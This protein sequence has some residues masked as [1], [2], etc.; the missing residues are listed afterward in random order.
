MGTGDHI[1]DLTFTTDKDADLPVDFPGEGGEGSCKLVGDDALGRNIPP[2]NLPDPLDF[3][4][5]ETG[6]VAM[7]FVDALSSSIKSSLSPFIPRRFA[8]PSSPGCAGLNA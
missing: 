1:G 4:R 8:S 3:F 7:D 5:S 6:Q 2:V